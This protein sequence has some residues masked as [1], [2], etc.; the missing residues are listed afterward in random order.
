MASNH[1]HG[2]VTKYTTGAHSIEDQALVQ[3]GANPSRLKDLAGTVTG[4]GLFGTPLD[5]AR[6]EQGVGARS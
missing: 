2:Q 5:V 3:I 6:S 1:L 4:K